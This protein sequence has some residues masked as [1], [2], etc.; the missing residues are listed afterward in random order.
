MY[1]YALLVY[2]PR[3]V[4]WGVV[5]PQIMSWVFVAAL[6]YLCALVLARTSSGKLIQRIVLA[7][8]SLYC[9]GEVCADSLRKRGNKKTQSLLS[10]YYVLSDLP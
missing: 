3:V 1:F 7:L 9:S 6:L 2:V 8:I 5:I 10:S 4:V